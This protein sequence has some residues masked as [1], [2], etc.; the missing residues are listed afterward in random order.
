MYSGQTYP[1]PIGQPSP[2]KPWLTVTT[3][4]IRLTHSKHLH[5]H[6]CAPS[7]SGLRFTDFNTELRVGGERQKFPPEVSAGN[8]S[9]VEGWA[10]NGK[11]NP[12]ER[13]DKLGLDVGHQFVLLLA[14]LGAQ[15]IIV[16]L[17]N[18]SEQDVLWIAVARVPRDVALWIQLSHELEGR[19]TRQK[20]YMRSV[21]TRR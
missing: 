11:L 2:C 18:Q 21:H 13:F 15:H 16:I 10:G 17:E 19:Q 3:P 8:G 7:E 5:G 20:D 1:Q 12:P 9:C 4:I 6:R 14:R